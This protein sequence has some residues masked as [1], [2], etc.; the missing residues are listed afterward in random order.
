[1]ALMPKKVY[2]NLPFA[3]LTQAGVALGLTA[4][5]YSRLIALNITEA[6]DAAILLLDV[7]VVSVLIAEIIGSLLLKFALMRSGEVKTAPT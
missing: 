5:T 4:F 2:N 6:T 1:M 7:V 3:L